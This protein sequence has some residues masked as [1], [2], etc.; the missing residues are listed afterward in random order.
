MYGQ[1]KGRGSL[2]AQIIAQA[3]SYG[4]RAENEAPQKPPTLKDQIEAQRKA[5][6]RQKILALP[7]DLQNIARVFE[8]RYVGE[9][10]N[11]DSFDAHRQEVEAGY[12]ATRHL[13]YSRKKGSQGDGEENSNGS[14]AFSSVGFKGPERLGAKERERARLARSQVSLFPNQGPG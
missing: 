13:W 9:S 4:H 3:K 6:E 11:G 7:E 5:R 10:L 1:E 2:K 8:A 12:Q 14:P